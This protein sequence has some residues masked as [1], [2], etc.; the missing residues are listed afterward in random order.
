M[1][2]LHDYLAAN[3]PQGFKPIPAVTQDGNAITWYWDDEPS[4][5]ES[6]HHD[7]TWV[8][9]V[10]RAFSDKRVVG[11]TIHTESVAGWTSLLASMEPTP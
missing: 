6:V 5:A 1:T 3:P 7:G 9:T 2:N 4:Y 8:G 10:H 11:V